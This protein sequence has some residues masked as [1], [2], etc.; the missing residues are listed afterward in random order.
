MSNISVPNLKEIKPWK[1]YYYVT[2]V[3]IF[4]ILCEEEKC[5][6]NQV[7]FKNKYLKKC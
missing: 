5:E 1:G 7:I 4:V 2:Y 3:N 6:Q